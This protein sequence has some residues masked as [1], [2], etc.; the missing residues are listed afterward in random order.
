MGT[1]SG[2][3]RRVKG[4]S[5]AEFRARFG[6]EAQRRPALRLGPEPLPELALTQPLDPPPNP[7][8]RTHSLTPPRPK[9]AW[10]L[11]RGR[12]GVTDNQDLF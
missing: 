10:M 3:R 9:P 11:A 12:L 1:E 5:E 7:T 8:L 4:L 6:T 2:L